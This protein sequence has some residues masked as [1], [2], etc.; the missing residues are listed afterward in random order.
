MAS[1]MPILASYNDSPLGAAKPQRLKPVTMGALFGT[2]EK[3]CT[4]TNIWPGLS[5]HTQS[6]P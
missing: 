6:S 5:R 3:S 2:T 4:D 1:A